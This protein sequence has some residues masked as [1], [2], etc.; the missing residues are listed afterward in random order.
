MNNLHTP[1]PYYQHTCPHCI[2]LGNFE[3]YDLYFCH[4]A[5]LDTVIARY[6]D[7]G[8]DYTSGL[9]FAEPFYDLVSKKNVSGIP[10]L[11]EAKKRATKAGLL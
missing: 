8:P 6:G 5:K 10:A 2:F 1:H 9:G 11:V 3:D 7:N 4:N